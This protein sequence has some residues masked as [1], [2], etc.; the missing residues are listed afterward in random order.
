MSQPLDLLLEIGCEEIPHDLL[1]D[2]IAGLRDGL[3][4]ALV[5]NR[6]TPTSVEAFGTPRR[7]VVV[8]RGLPA[9]QPTVEE[10][11]TGPP[12]SAA[13][14]ASGTFTRA[15]EG[16]AAKL[17][18]PTASLFTTHTERGPYIAA[19]RRLPGRPARAVLPE[20]LPGVLTALHWAK[21]MRWADGRGPFVRPVRWI[22]AV[23]GGKAVRFEFAG[24]RASNQ[25]RGHRFM[26]PKKPFGVNG[27]DDYLAKIRAACVLVDPEERRQRIREQLG[28][29]AATLGGKVIADET[30]VTV[31]AAKSEWPVAVPGRFESKYLEV[32]REVLITSM[33]EH[34]DDFAIEDAA[35]NLLPAFVAFA[36]NQA[37][38]LSVVAHGNQRV[39]RARLEDARF[40]FTEDKKRPLAEYAPRLERLMFQKELGSVADKVQ[41]IRALATR[42]APALGANPQHAAR[43]AE[44]AKCDLVTGMVYEFPEL[45]GTMGRVYAL[46]SGEPQAVA[47]AI[48][49]H[50]RPRFSGDTPP[51]TPEGRAVA[52]ADKLD[53]ICAIFAIGKVPSGS[54]DPYALRRAGLG[55]MQILAEQP[56]AVNLTETVSATVALLTIR[57]PGGESLAD[58]VEIF[59]RD[60]LAHQ[61]GE[62]GLRYD[63]VAACLAPGI[64]DVHD[65]RQ[66]AHALDGLRRSEPAEFDNLMT[67]FRRV[68]KII[69][70]G[71]TPAPVAADRLANGPEQALWGAFATH[72]ERIGDKTTS[73]TDRLAVMAAL[74]PH[75]DAF[76]DAVL[77]MDPDENVRDNRL[78]MLA[79]IG[80]AFGAFADFSLIVVD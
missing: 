17:G 32:P 12:E 39:L 80:E 20:L 10:T 54:Q 61:L 65:A 51:T 25:T 2:G 56:T 5:Q 62:E 69:P 22:C 78:S 19:T 9:R 55:I 6:L 34:Q 11:V 45:Q 8:V 74:R 37:V 36:D 3:R 67:S 47:A 38:D 50:Y 52:L 53:T 75:V 59:L 16:F 58:R 73:A 70:V 66:R 21:T 77:V 35:G 24:T 60:R 27:P 72:R 13:R 7:L 57:I 79:S 49:D 30:L 4:Q 63:V 64:A 40:F 23:L 44:L 42:L 46:N 14:D 1:T 15:A 31:T 29:A 71:F 28:Q 41:R 68:I 26:G 33:R 18:V 48:G 76:F 43:A